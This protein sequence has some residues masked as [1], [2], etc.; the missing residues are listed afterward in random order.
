MAL[1]DFHSLQVF[2]NKRLEQNL[3]CL[4]ELHNIQCPTLAEEILF[5]FCFD[6][7]PGA[8]TLTLGQVNTLPTRLRR[9]QFTIQL[10]IIFELY[11]ELSN[12]DHVLG[13]VSQT[14]VSDGNR[15]HD[16]TA[17]S[18]AHCLLDYQST[19]QRNMFSFIIL[20]EI[21]NLEFEP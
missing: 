12:F 1:R 21:F 10:Q 2:V 13:V 17:N 14:R 5:V 3:A 9:L 4:L 16:P 7:W 8:R 6:I 11:Y 20:L 18:L 15:I 19:N